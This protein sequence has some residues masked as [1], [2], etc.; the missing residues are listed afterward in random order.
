MLYSEL[1]EW[2]INSNI[3]KRLNTGKILMTKV[4]RQ[5]KYHFDFIDLN[6]HKLSN[7]RETLD[8]HKEWIIRIKERIENFG[9]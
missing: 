6:M 2:Y 5:L 8:L 4:D 1:K 7:D 9:Y 3:P